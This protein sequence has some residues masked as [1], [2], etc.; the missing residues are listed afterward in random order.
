MENAGSE[1][2]LLQS[3]SKLAAGDYLFS[4]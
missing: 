3:E 4:K 1:V 2:K